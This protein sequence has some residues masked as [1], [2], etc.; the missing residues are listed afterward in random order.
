M[1][2]ASLM[3]HRAMCCRA[4]YF[5]QCCVN[6]PVHTNTFANLPI[7][8][9]C[10]CPC[11]FWGFQQLFHHSCMSAHL[12]IYAIPCMCACIAS[13]VCAR[14]SDGM[15]LSADGEV[16][17]KRASCGSVWYCHGSLLFS[18]DPAQQLSLLT[19]CMDGMTDGVTDGRTGGRTNRQTG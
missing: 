9:Q 3:C 10:L 7:C 1:L 19:S 4:V 18:F 12:L 2:R 16:R 14:T 6:A 17:S 5:R 8:M 13:F 11:K 15:R